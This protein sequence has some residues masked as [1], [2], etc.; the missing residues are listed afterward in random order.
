MKKIFLPFI[1]ILVC[2]AIQMNAQT[3]G[4]ENTVVKFVPTDPKV[5]IKFKSVVIDYGKIAHYSDGTKEF[6]FTNTGTKPL[7]I[8]SVQGSCGCTVPT[9]PKQA[10]KPGASNKIIVKYATD[11]VGKF[12]KSVTVFSNAANGSV[13]LTIKGDVSPLPK[14]LP[15]GVKQFDPTK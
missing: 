12:E 14:V 4:H 15:P 10:I 11:R 7:I 3:K 13:V 1:F 2:Q 6:I 9:W 5:T 8:S